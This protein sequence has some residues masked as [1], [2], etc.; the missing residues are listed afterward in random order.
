MTSPRFRASLVSMVCSTL[1]LPIG[2]ATDRFQVDQA[3]VL[4]RATGL[5]WQRGVSP[6]FVTWN[7]AQA[8]C[9][10]LQLG[11]LGGWRAPTVKELVSLVDFATTTPAIDTGTFPTG[12]SILGL[13]SATPTAASVPGWG[14]SA[15]YL[16]YSNG[17]T[18]PHPVDAYEGM[19]VRCIIG[20]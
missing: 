12:N 18:D 6:T 13:W 17:N 16:L 14:P 10:D 4:D 20:S 3:I 15:W 2:C 7:D 5:R 11:G 9:A 8:Y 19:G 1:L